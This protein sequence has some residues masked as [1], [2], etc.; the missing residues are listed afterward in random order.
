MDGDCCNYSI[1]IVAGG[2]CKKCYIREM[3]Q[4]TIHGECKIRLALTPLY[5]TPLGAY[6]LHHYTHR[7][8]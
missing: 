6:I 3:S 2:C 1:T 4:M 5:N 7:E 8:L